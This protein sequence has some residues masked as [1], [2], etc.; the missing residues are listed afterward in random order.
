M[1]SKDIIDV[2]EN[3]DACAFLLLHAQG[4]PASLALRYQGKVSFSLHH[5]LMLLVIYKKAIKKI[6]L[7]V[8]HHLAIDRRSYQQ[9]TSQNIAIY[10]QSK[11]K[12][13]RML[14]LTGG[15]GVDSLFLADSFC[16]C[17]VV[18][19][20]EDLNILAAYNLQKLGIQNVTRI[21][22]DATAFLTTSED[23][24]DLVYIDPDRR[25]SETRKLLLQDLSP[26]VLDLL[27]EMPIHA[28]RV[29]I[30]LSPLFDV[31]EIWRHI[32]QTT[33]IWI[34]S[35]R[36]EVKE[37]GV[38]LDYS[39]SPSRMIRLYETYS[40]AEYLLDAGRTASLP[41][42]DSVLRYLHIPYASVAKSRT[43]AHFFGEEEVFQLKDFAIYTSD[44][45]YTSGHRNFQVI[46][47]VSC[48]VKATK[49]MLSKHGVFRCNISVKGSQEMPETWH[50]KLKTKDGGDHYLFIFR[51][52][53]Q[54]AV[55]ARFIS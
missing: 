39:A 50:K 45:E 49:K 33:E 22:A 16:S 42:T 47:K 46:E 43:S 19:R 25:D 24:Y 35:E 53:M 6:P 21:D 44:I 28:A 29:Y 26:N 40:K 41:N 13:Q 17:T 1:Q 12:G 5:V 11:W 18:E 48:G 31:E 3:K 15:I 34:L 51:N 7:F 8:E 55:L 54:T 38:Y 20:N 27:P 2:L 52:D 4:D 9:A 10:K 37:V 36:N 23:K 30:K 14:D 32:P